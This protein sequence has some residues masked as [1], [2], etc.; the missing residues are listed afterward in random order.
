MDERLAKLEARMDIIVK[1]ESEKEGT[2]MDASEKNA[3]AH[4]FFEE[5]SCNRIR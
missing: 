5:G 3:H 2:G 1:Q 4:I